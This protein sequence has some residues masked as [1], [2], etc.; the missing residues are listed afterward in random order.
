MKLKWLLVVMLALAV[1]IPAFALLDDNSTNLNNQQQQ[2][3]DNR[4]TNTNINGADSRSTI[5]N[6]SATGGSSNASVGNTSATGGAGGR[7]ESDATSSAGNVSG[8]GNRAYSPSADSTQ[9][10][11][12]GQGQMQ[13]QGQLQGQVGNTTDV[14]VEGDDVEGSIAV[15]YPSQSSQKGQAASTV[16]SM[17][18]GFSNAQTEE[19][20]KMLEVLTAIKVIE[21]YGYITHEEAV[22]EAREYLAQLKHV[23]KER[24]L[25]GILWKTNSNHLLNGM[26]LLS[27]DPCG[28]NI[29]SIGQALTSPMKSKPSTDVATERVDNYSAK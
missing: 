28:I 19:Y 15:A 24:R 7:S 12:Q 10:Q 14:N 23:S 2:S 27:W 18:G 1:A 3:S 9:L 5:G 4:N 22:V 25:L 11:G 16:Y 29:D 13:G 8:L 21:G 17:F 26:G 20:L 6:T